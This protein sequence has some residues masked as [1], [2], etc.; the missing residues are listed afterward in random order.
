MEPASVR[1]VESDATTLPRRRFYQPELD[2]LRFFAFFAVFIFHTLPH[3]TDYYSTRHIP[4]AALIASVS[5]AGS[6]GVDLFFLLSAYLISQLLLREKE[7]FGHVSLKAFYLRRI[8]RIWPLYFLAIFIGVLLT[9][10]DPTQHF[11]AKYVIAF[12]LLSGN[13]LQSLIGAPGSV[14]NPLWSVSFE[15]QFY[16][17]WPTVIS[18]VRSARSLLF[19]CLGLFGISEVGRLV[20]LRYARYSEVTIFTNSVARLDPL[21]L[22]IIIAVLTR[23]RPLSFTWMARGALLAAG[24]TVWLLAGHYF[25]MTRTFMLLGYPMMAIGAGLIF[26]SV[27]ESGVAPAWLRYLGKISYGLYVFHVLALYLVENAIGGYAKNFH[28][29]FVFWSGG[30][31]LTLVMA[32]LSYRFVE[33]PFLRLKER[34]ALVKSRP[35]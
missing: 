6:F 9:L 4:F 23:S 7:T 3:E 16:L 26:L 17:V 34:Y 30:L 8:L 19:V 31:A 21:A 22:G 1:A 33:S 2:C 28:K 35:V 27:L 10:V 5:R 20:L 12:L 13:W 29:F 14:M 32:A 25:S 15:E 11:P 24:I 18:K